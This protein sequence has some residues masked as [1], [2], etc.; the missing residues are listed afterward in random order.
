MRYRLRTLLIVLAIGP[1]V[2]A[3][4]LVAGRAIHL[5]R[6]AA[7]FLLR[8]ATHDKEAEKIAGKRCPPEDRAGTNTP[9]Y[10]RKYSKHRKLAEEYRNAAEKPW[11]IVRET[12]P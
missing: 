4:A 12:P 8:A 3:G 9:R 2:L 6:R 1:P 11:I 7:D 5:Q 10:M